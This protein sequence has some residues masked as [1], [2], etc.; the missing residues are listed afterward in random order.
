MLPSLSEGL[1]IVLVEAQCNGLPCVVS[2][3]V[4]KEV[5]FSNNVRYLS[6]KSS[7]I[8]WA[9]NVIEMFNYREIDSK[10]AKDRVISNGYDIV[11]AANELDNFYTELLFR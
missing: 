5:A 8:E 3:S 6:L 2:D 4:T 7:A 11:D 1:P 10:I 9:D